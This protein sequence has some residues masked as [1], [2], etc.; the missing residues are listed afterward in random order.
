MEG[1]IGS[2]N[3]LTHLLQL[4]MSYFDEIIKNKKTLLKRSLKKREKKR[5][6]L[7]MFHD[8]TML[9]QAR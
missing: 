7:A 6:K 9:Y 3:S 1:V 8:H 4:I 2:F 5:G